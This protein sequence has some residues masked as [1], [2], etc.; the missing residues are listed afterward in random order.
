MIK[1]QITKEAKHNIEKDR[2]SMKSKYWL[3][4]GAYVRQR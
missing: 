4:T 2:R 3:A 1:T